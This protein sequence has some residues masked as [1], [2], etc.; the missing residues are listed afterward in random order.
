MNRFTLL[1]ILVIFS[2]FQV[3]FGKRRKEG[4][5]EK[6]KKEEEIRKCERQLSRGG[7]SLR[8]LL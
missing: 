3:T 8:V 5:K 1:I 7:L 6:K 4:R 2:I